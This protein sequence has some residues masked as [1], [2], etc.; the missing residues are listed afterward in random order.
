[1]KNVFIVF[2]GFSA[3]ALPAAAFAA[4]AGTPNLYNGGFGQI[5]GN[6]QDFGVAVCNGGA[7]TV[8]QAVPVSVAVGGQT[9]NI[10][11]PAPLK[12]GACAYSYLTYSQLGMQAG[13][14]YS[15][16]VTVNGASQAVYRITV[17]GGAAA[18]AATLNA[19]N[20]TAN[21]NAQFGDFFTMMQNWFKG[22]FGT[23]Q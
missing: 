18:G 8:T 3:V 10:L 17:P 23:Q 2:L 7:A 9:A 14:S 16:T 11:S 20:G 12:P 5:A 6:T 19:A 21:A 15:V 1:M 4:G 22:M 13:A